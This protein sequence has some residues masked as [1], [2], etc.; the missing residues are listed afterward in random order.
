MSIKFKPEAL[1][2]FAWA[3][4]VPYITSIVSCRRRD[5]IRQVAD[6]MGEPWEKTYRKGGRAIRVIVTA[7]KNGAT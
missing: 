5:L 4:D 7:S 1:W 2:A 3:R 6:H